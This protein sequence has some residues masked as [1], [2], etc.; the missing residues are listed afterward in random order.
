MGAFQA[1]PGYFFFLSETQ[2]C[3]FYLCFSYF[4]ILFQ[5]SVWA[6]KK[7]WRVHK[8]GSACFPHGRAVA[9]DLGLCGF[10]LTLVFFFPCTQLSQLSDRHIAHVLL[11]E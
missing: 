2:I 3:Y 9:F 8:A 10:Y 5:R 6:A 4:F 1:L 7:E 11:L